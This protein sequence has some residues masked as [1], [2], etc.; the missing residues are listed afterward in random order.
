M[1]YSILDYRSSISGVLQLEVICLW[2]SDG[3]LHTGY[4]GKKLLIY[5]QNN[6]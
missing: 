4:Y 2:G 5:V 3:I 1:G 6:G